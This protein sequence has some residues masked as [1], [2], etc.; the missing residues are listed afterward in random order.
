MRGLDLPALPRQSGA[1]RWFYLDVAAGDVTCV[2]IFM[3]GSVFSPRY[4]A[5]WARGATPLE[6]CAV[7]VA[8]YR[9]GERIAW[10]LTEY[11]HAVQ[12]GAHTL[13]IGRS[14]LHY[15]VQGRVEV[16]VVE[17]TAPWGRPLCVRAQLTPQA[18]PLEAVTLVEGTSHR[19]RPLAPRAEIFLEAQWGN[20]KRFCATQGRGYHDTNWGEEPLGRSVPGWQWA[21]SH[22]EDAT[23]IWYLPPGPQAFEVTAS[24]R[25]TTLVR[26]PSE[27]PAAA[28]MLT[29]WGLKVPRVLRMGSVLCA[30]AALLESSPFYARL[31]AST[32]G[33]HALA[34]VADFRRFHSPFIRWMAH[35]R[36]RVESAA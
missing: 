9:H 20:A 34:E 8:L 17:R 22:A 21:R 11:P 4:S 28:Q 15:D 12:E 33:V 32:P 7:N 26:H 25:G 1:Y 31:E 6:H 3:V 18:P 16:D 36:T 5:G 19:W 2:I 30:P 35:F 29:R 27:T 10:A 13:R 23:T 14:R 24:D